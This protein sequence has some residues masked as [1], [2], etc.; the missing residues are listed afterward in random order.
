MTVLVEVEKKEPLCSVNPGNDQET[1]V[2]PGLPDAHEH[3]VALA[4]KRPSFRA[5]LQH[6]VELSDAGT[7][8]IRH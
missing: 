1:Q 4:G 7:A 3:S 2:R 8:L 5:K 6:L